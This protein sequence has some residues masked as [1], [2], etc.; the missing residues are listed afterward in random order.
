MQESIYAVRIQ[1]D[2]KTRAIFERTASLVGGC[3][4]LAEDAAC[5]CDLL[6]IE[7]GD[8]PEKEL[9]RLNTIQ[10]SG[11]AR[12]IFLT[13]ESTAPKILINAMRAGVKE[14]FSQPINV[15]DVENALLKFKGRM[16]D[17]KPGAA[18]VKNA[19]VIAVQG[20]KGGVGTTTVAVNL[21]GSLVGLRDAPSVALVDLNL[22]LGEVPLFLNVQPTFD[23]MEIANNISRLDGTYLMSIL[24][25]HRSGLYVLS[26]PVKLLEDQT[27]SP[28]AVESV[29]KLMQQSFDFIVVDVGQ[30]L[31]DHSKVVL[32]AADRLLLVATPTLPC[33]VNLK[34]L[35]DAFKSIGY[36]PDQSIEIVFN[37]SNQKGGISPAEAEQ[38]LGKE[39]SWHFPN[40]YRSAVEAINSGEPL[41][42]AAPRSELNRKIIAMAARLAGKT[43][44]RKAKRAFFFGLL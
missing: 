3:H 39:V 6:I 44:E 20:S 28:K 1:T 32:K 8:D 14:F 40:D 36:P 38:A 10:A 34:R 15:Q 33:M 26:S 2:R 29:L 42:V 21:A 18:P 5:P 23:W 24:L 17:A 7:I 12:E 27:P 41:S 13:S 4:V 11:T 9:Q 43:E 16:E 31:D 22:L 37:R 19:K 35:L 30:C 25:K